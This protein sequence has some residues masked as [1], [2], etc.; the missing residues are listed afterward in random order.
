MSSEPTTRVTP[1]NAQNSFA[2]KEKEADL[3]FFHDGS[4]AKK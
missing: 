2:Q 4:F 1:S 3:E